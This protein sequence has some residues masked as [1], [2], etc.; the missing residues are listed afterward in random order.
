MKYL[1]PYSHDRPEVALGKRRATGL[2]VVSARLIKTGG[3]IVHSVNI[4]KPAEQKGIQADYD[5]L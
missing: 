4:Y 2:I 1:Q 3:E 5:A